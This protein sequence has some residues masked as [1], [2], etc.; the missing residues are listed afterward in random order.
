MLGPAHAALLEGKTLFV[1]TGDRFSDE[2]RNNARLR[3]N[4]FSSWA[5]TKGRRATT[6]IREKGDQMGVYVWLVP[7]EA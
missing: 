2:S 5:R 6:R 1:P 3:A 4:G 7:V